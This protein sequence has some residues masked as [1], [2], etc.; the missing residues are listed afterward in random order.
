MF[1]TARNR[2]S[3]LD[4]NRNMHQHCPYVVSQTAKLPPCQ[5]QHHLK[6]ALIY[7]KISTEP[8]GYRKTTAILGRKRTRVE[9]VHA[10]SRG[11]AQPL[12]ANIWNDY[13]DKGSTKQGR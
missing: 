12:S 1:R 9:Y 4:H 6:H 3:C 2:H 13:H 11:G 8:R 7:R 10:S 5:E